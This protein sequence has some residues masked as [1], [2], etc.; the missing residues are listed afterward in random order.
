MEQY[1]SCLCRCHGEI[2]NKDGR[3]NKDHEIVHIEN[4]HLQLFKFTTDEMEAVHSI[5]CHEEFF[6]D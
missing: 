3:I 5:E 6:D 4:C 2:I 1:V